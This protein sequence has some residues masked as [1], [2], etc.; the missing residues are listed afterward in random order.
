MFLLIRWYI[1][2]PRIRNAVS[3]VSL[4]KKKDV[5]K[6]YCDFSVTVLNL[7]HICEDN[8]STTIVFTVLYSYIRILRYQQILVFA[9]TGL[10]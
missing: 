4:E 8:F 10:A 6:H 5:Q 2:V 7:C 9:V 1:A 3:L